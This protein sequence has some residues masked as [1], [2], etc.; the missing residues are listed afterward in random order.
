MRIRSIGA[1]VVGAFLLSGPWMANA[2]DSELLELAKARIQDQG[3]PEV[4]E[5]FFENVERGV[6]VEQFGR[7]P[8]DTG[9]GPRT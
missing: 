8:A 3:E 1:V 9:G 2:S 6:D 7:R 5:R 4:F